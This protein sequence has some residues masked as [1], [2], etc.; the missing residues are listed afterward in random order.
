MPVKN[1]YE[2]LE[3][4]PTASEDEIKKAKRKLM[5]QY[6]PVKNKPVIG[7]REER[8]YVPS[9]QPSYQP[10]K[11]AS[12]HS[13]RTSDFDNFFKPKSRQPGQECDA[14]FAMPHSKPRVYKWKSARPSFRFIVID[15]DRAADVVTD[16]SPRTKPVFESDRSAFHVQQIQTQILM[17]IIQ[18]LIL[19]EVMRISTNAA[20]LAAVAACLNPGSAHQAPAFRCR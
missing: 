3:I 16:F 15:I 6:H 7:T 17:A 14:E 2:V 4:N 9:P 5:L 13:T 19:H 18:S 12:Q 1:Y 10:P 8:T 11:P 20:I